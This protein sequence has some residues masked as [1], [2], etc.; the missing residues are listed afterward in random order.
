[1]IIL[2]LLNANLS[3]NKYRHF[4]LHDSQADIPGTLNT[5]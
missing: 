5:I 2:L 4:R 3:R 1:M